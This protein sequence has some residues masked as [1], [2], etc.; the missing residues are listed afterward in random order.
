MCTVSTLFL[1]QQVLVLFT[2]PVEFKGLI[3]GDVFEHIFRDFLGM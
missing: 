3:L 2:E 1:E